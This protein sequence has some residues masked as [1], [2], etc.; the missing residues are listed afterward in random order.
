MKF[1]FDL[2]GTVT[3]VETLPIISKHFN[4]SDEINQLTNDTVSGNIPFIESF[5]R[6]IHILGKLPVSEINQLLS[7]VPLFEEV[8]R[9]IRE[10]REDCVLATGNFNGWVDALAQKI[11]CQYY[12]SK[13][14]VEEDKIVKLTYILKKEDIVNKFKAQGEKVIFIGDG[15][16]DV[17]AM[18]ISDIS[19]ACGLVHDPAKSVLAVANYSVYSEKALVRLLNQLCHRQRSGKSVVLS[20]A[21]IGSRLGLGQT[22]ALIKIENKPLIHYQ[23]ESFKKI[24]DIRVVVG[25]QADEV[26]KTALQKRKDII[27]VYNHDYFHTKTGTSY[28]LGA[29][30]ANNYVI[31]WDGDLLVHPDDVNRCLEFN[32]E[33]VGCSQSITDDAVFVRMNEKKEVVGFSRENGDYEWSGPAC[34]KR[35]HIGY[36]SGHVYSQIEKHLPLPAML[37]RAQ[38]VDT[39]EDYTKAKKFVKSWYGGNFLIDAYYSKMAK[40]IDSPL[41]TRNKAKDSSFYDIALMKRLA[42]STKTLLDLGSGTGLLINHLVNDFASITAV[43]KYRDFSKYIVQS[44]KVEIINEDI[45]RFDTK[46]KYDMVS[47]FGVMNYFNLEESKYIYRKIWDFLKDDGVLIIKNQMGI[48]EDVLINGYSDELGTEYYSH[49]RQVDKEMQLLHEIGFSKI[50]KIDIYPPEF[51]RWDNTHFY[52]LLCEKHIKT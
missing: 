52:A 15:N 30:D 25:Y 44:P 45:L 12:S 29:K 43:E 28:Y 35:D 33:F 47:L 16:N 34:L 24:E 32:G 42:N 23:V 38:D 40:K 14:V 49:Y 21:G 22:K 17:E 7:E 2:D 41:V 10:N 20:C 3:S 48:K 31:A 26:I 37:I 36:T 8:L 13:G 46:K 11:G 9:F 1:I 27:F 6:R 50:E 4:V 18:R 19:I 5:I 39:Y 51:S